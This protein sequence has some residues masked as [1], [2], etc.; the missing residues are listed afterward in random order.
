MAP[1]SVQSIVEG[2]IMKKDNHNTKTQTKQSRPNN[3]LIALLIFGTL[4]VMFAFI[5]GYKYF[6]LT[7]S[8]EKYMEDMGGEA[9]FSNMQVGDDAVMSITADGNKLSIVTNVT[10][11]DVKAAKKEY[12]G[13]DA[14]E[15]MEY[16][17]AY[18]LY[19]FKSNCRGLTAKAEYKVNINKK[20]V[21][22]ISISYRKA[23]K[24]L[25]D[26]GMLSE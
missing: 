17:A 1:I 22:S 19:S 18:Y 4:A 3:G 13:D 5:W 8:I 23:K 10:T 2:K 15:N 16:L 21:N 11:D 12:T 6:Q 26:K 24:I 9:L 7:P 20:E 14:T 25:K